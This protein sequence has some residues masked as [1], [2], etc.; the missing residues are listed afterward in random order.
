MTEPISP[1]VGAVAAARTDLAKPLIEV[2]DLVFYRGSRVI[3]DGVN[4]Q[5]RRGQ[6]TGIMGPSGT[7][8]TTLLRIIAGLEQA[9]N[10]QILLR[11]NDFTASSAG[12]RNIG[13]VPQSFALYPHF[14]VR[15][16][17]SYPLDLVGAAAARLHR[18]GSGD[19]IA[20]EKGA[21]L[22]PRL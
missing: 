7:G 8:K 2:K 20:K 6:I 5:I 13:Y 4:L 19:L 17:I 22:K 14:S 16:N 1:V 18:L 10:G 15:K 12:E 9:D 3:Y 11:G 21:V